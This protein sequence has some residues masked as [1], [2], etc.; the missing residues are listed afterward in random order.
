MTAHLSHATQLARSRCGRFPPRQGGGKPRPRGADS[1]VAS[2]P[3]VKF[4]PLAHPNRVAESGG[5]ARLETEHPHPH[6]H[7]P[8]TTARARRR[9]GSLR[10]WGR[11]RRG[12][13]PWSFL[14]MSRDGS[15]SCL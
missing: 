15:W 2:G 12:A 13:P 7:G 6:P 1:V 5:A 11:R 10:R 9:A 8:G 14:T 3:A 4:I